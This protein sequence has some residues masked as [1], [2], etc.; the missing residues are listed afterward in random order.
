M[1]PCPYLGFWTASLP[2]VFMRCD[3]VK[4]GRR[5]GAVPNRQSVLVNGC[6]VMGT[7][8]GTR[9]TDHQ[10]SCERNREQGYYKLDLQEDP[11]ITIT[12]LQEEQKAQSRD[13]DIPEQAE[14]Q[15]P[16]PVEQFENARAEEPVT[17]EPR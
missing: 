8:P 10:K 3:R 11:D 16:K 6:T 7:R 9:E 13:K 14:K 12:M 1:L 5:H 17:E 15:F 2:G 4:N